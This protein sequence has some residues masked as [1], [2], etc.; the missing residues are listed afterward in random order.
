MSYGMITDTVSVLSPIN[1]DIQSKKV[2][3]Y[4]NNLNI[5]THLHNR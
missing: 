4:A 1:I 3:Q 2:L 5:I